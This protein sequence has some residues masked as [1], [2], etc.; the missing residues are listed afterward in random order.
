MNSH[1][2]AGYDEI[3]SPYTPYTSKITFK[4][5]FFI[6]SRQEDIRKYYDFYPKVGYLPL[7]QSEEAD[8]AR[9]SEPNSRNLPTQTGSSRSSTRG[10]SATPRYSRMKSTF[11][12]S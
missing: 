11:C 10:V 12:G 7:S 6:Q 1:P 3:L 9:F 5:D 2:E 4:K 8:T